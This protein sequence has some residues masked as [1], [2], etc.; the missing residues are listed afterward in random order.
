MI[1]IPESAKPKSTKL[2]S[3][4]L[5]VELDITGFVFFAAFAVMLLLALQWGGTTHPWDSATIIG[6]FC[7]SG[8]VLMIFAVWE[9]RVGDSAMMPFSMLKKRVVWSACLVIFF[10]FGAMVIFSY[11]LPIYFQAVKGVS[12][13]L[14]GVYLLPGILGQMLTAVVSGVLGEYS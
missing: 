9:Y 11:Y 1:K 10:F 2:T 3:T 4:S 6:L 8:V 12:P 13:A 5:L 7:G 14:S